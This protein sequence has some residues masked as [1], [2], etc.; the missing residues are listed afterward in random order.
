MSYFFDTIPYIEGNKKLRK[1]QIEAY[2]KIKEFF[3]EEPNGEALVVLPTGTGKSG[4]IS[5]APF[6]VAN[7]RVLIITPGLV[8][9]KSVIKTLHPLEDNFWINYDVLF[10]IEDIPVVEEYDS[11]MLDESL[12]K[13]NFVIANIHKLNPDNPNSLVNRVSSDFF[14]MVIVDEAHHAPANTWQYALK[15]FKDAK[16]LHVTGTPYRGDDRELPGVEIHNTSLSEVMSLKYVKWL[17]KR[18]VNN[19]ALFFTIPGDSYKY[20]KEEVLQMKEKEWVE[21]SVALSKEC[22]MDVIEE[23]IKQLQ[24]LKAS[25]PS[26]PHKILAAACSI[27]HAENLA[28]WY[29]GKNLKVV[30]VHSKMSPEQLEENLLKI[31]NHECQVVVSVNMLMEGYDHKY[32]TVLAIFRPYRSLNAFAQIIGRILRAIPDEEIVDFAIDNNAV[33]IYHEETG[34]N[35]MWEYFSSEVEISKHI[36]TRDYDF[37]E[38]EYNERDNNYAKIEK[39]EYFIS[40]TDSYIPDLD[41]NALFEE[42]RNRTELKVKDRIVKLQELGWSDEEIKATESGLRKAISAKEKQ[43]IDRLL[44]DKRPEMARKAIREILFTNANDAAQVLLQEKNIDPKACSLYNKFRY[45]VHGLTAQTYNDGILVRYINLKVYNRFGKVDKRD[46]ET[47]L[48]SQKYMGEIINE[49][50]RML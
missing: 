36:S 25:S 24:S 21:K 19:S 44:I 33:V 5:I 31:E 50:R 37:S 43:G 11:G 26:V 30:I 40:E 32:L 12:E 42:A 34:L 14:N 29:E 28:S 46:N 47:L 48:R 2:L 8:T 23:S 38:K 10:D 22:S 16:K 27:N 45:L 15:Y 17:R 13:C 1:P 35:S 41:F 7:G 18:T 39:N 9:K 4:L 20:S 6:G 49:L 3:Q